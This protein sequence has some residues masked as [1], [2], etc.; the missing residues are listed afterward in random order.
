MF[1]KN[2]HMSRTNSPKHRKFLLAFGALLL[3]AACLIVLRSQSGTDAGN[4][5]VVSGT[6]NSRATGPTSQSG[7]PLEDQPAQT[8]GGKDRSAPDAPRTSTRPRRPADSKRSGR[9]SVVDLMASWRETPPWPEGPR[10]YAEVET[11]SKR[12]VNLRPNGMG[13]MPMLNAKPKE[14]L[15]VRLTLPENQP[16]DAIYLELP[17]G[18][19]FP[20]EELRGKT[21]AVSDA[22]TLDFQMSAAAARGNCTIYI[23]Q[24]GHTRTLP[25]WIGEP[26]A[27]T[28]EDTPDPNLP[29][30]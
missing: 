27:P 19:N 18:G 2:S 15:S 11:S 26:D 25:L 1:Q 12:Y 23:R 21:M 13:I 6:P 17:N 9:I 7:S 24:A 22:R 16:G 14:T 5:R 28:G 8:A 10:L 3:G 4:D 29:A 30:S 20:G